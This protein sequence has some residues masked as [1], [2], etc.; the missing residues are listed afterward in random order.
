MRILLSLLILASGVFGDELLTGY[1]LQGLRYQGPGEWRQSA[2]PIWVYEYH[3]LRFRYRASG[4]PKSDAAVLTLRP[5][6]VGPVT[7]GANN[8]E[9]PFVAGRPVVVV[10]APDLISDG[11]V[12]TVDIEL[13]GKLRTAQIDQLQFALPDGATLEI[14]DLQFRGDPAARPCTTAGPPLPEDAVKLPARGP[15]ACAGWPATGLRGRDSIH[16]EGGG[17]K[18]AT[19][20]LSMNAQFPG[21]GKWLVSSQKSWRDTEIKE[22]SETASVLARIHYADGS[23]EEQ[24]PLLVAERRHAV[25]NRKAAL[26][27]LSLDA[28]R[29]V[30]SIELMDRSPHA[31][32]VLYAAGL[33]PK[34]APSTRAEEEPPP[35]T[36]PASGEPETKS[37]YRVTT[38]EGKRAPGKA[39]QAEFREE[40]QPAG[41]RLSLAVKNVSSEAQEFNLVFPSVTIRPAADAS[42]VWYLFPRQGAVLS[43]EEKPLEAMYS[44]EFP[45]QFVDV[46]APA[47]N[48]GTCMILQDPGGRWKKF[49]L[50]KTGA[51]VRVEVE[52]TVRLAPGETFRAPDARIVAHGGDWRQGFETY[53][54]W[55]ATWYKP[56]GPRPAWLRSAFWARRDYPVGG[57][58]RLFDTRRNRYTYDEFIRDGQL[59]DGIDFIDISGWAL[60]ETRGR[61]G[62][63]SIELGGA[64]DLRRNVAAGNKAGIPTGLYFEGYL[65]DK[66]SK[67]GREHGS[68]WQII[69]ADGTGQW[70]Q[71]AVELFACPYAEGW[72]QFLSQRV[73]AVARE[74]GAAAVY[75][76]EF[77]FGR[78]RCYSTK[79]GHPPGEET[80]CGELAMT[81]RVRQALDAAGMRDTIIYIEETPPD[82]AA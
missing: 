8:I 44:G 82:A 53:R 65:I 28:A 81:S 63:Y 7:P 25:L 67:V 41:R 13:R 51:S 4:L 9:N 32:L 61:V 49:R 59:F 45:L 38:L 58:G 37:T 42:D 16:I 19:L 50:H 80:L 39:V 52:Y 35:V 17:R 46:F 30:A 6:S 27:A 64:D 47:A 23:G 48:R 56:K 68:E 77:G 66:N 29:P 43:R 22:S 36:G 54:Q 26:Y 74:V 14:E 15:L 40:K 1:R 72:Q 20:Y 24:F 3:T 76:D 73:A 34:S 79:H 69:K 60:S 10:T 18:G 71:G 62:D 5:G 31:Q 70:W 2:E 57:T 33:S 21:V 78:K 75:L 11:A 12:H 55:V